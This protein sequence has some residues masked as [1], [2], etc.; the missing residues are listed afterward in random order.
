MTKYGRET[1]SCLGWSGY[2]RRT[3]SMFM[4]ELTLPQV[5]EDWTVSV[6]GLGGPRSYAADQNIDSRAPYRVDHP[7]GKES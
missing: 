6:D 5:M 4:M 2:V 3:L 7:D 1:G